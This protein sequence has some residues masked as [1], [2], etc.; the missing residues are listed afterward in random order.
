MS[1]LEQTPLSPSTSYRIIPLTQGQFAI[2]DADDYDWL[3]KHKWHAGWNTHT[4][5][6]YAKRSQY[7]GTVD[8]KRII[9]TFRMH[10]EILGLKVG[11][12]WVDHREPSETLDNRKDNLRK[13]SAGQNKSNSR[14]HSNNTSGYKGVSWHKRIKKYG[15]NIMVNGKSRHLGY[16]DDPSE[17]HA[18]RCK[19][20]EEMHGEFA[21]NE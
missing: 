6:Y 10:R 1:L 14:I 11:D 5:S 7:M 12:P 20:A 15:V 4:Q 3:S 21:R 18:V 8:G 13:A 17:G 2:V 9:K 19:A 16:F